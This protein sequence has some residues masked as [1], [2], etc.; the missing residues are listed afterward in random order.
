MTERIRQGE[1]ALI[2]EPGG[3]FR[4]CVPKDRKVP[5][6]TLLTG[7]AALL[8]DRDPELLQRVLRLGERV[9]AEGEQ[10]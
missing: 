7:I 1:S 2:C 8:E 5:A 10:P 6:G 9:I 3:G 4:F